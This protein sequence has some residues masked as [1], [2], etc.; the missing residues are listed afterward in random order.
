[1]MFSSRHPDTLQGLVD[2]LAEIVKW[3]DEQGGPGQLGI[4]DPIKGA[5]DM[6]ARQEFPAAHSSQPFD[7]SPWSAPGRGLRAERKLS[8]WTRLD[9]E[10]VLFASA[11]MLSDSTI[12]GRK[13]LA[14][15]N[16]DFQVKS[17]TSEKRLAGVPV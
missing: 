4:V 11:I 13:F 16:Y 6:R 14:E 1:M 8:R 15:I 3:V 10:F 9:F 5:H 12:A 7:L 17:L 2:E